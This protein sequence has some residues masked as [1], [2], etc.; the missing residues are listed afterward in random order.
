MSKFCWA[1]FRSVLFFHVFWCFFTCLFLLGSGHYH[2]LVFLLLE[3]FHF[4]GHF[5]IRNDDELISFRLLFHWWNKAK[6]IHLGEKACPKKAHKTGVCFSLI[7]SKTWTLYLN[8]LLYGKAFMCT[9]L[10]KLFFHW[11][12]LNLIRIKYLHENKALMIY[13]FILRP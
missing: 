2:S 7:H 9:V 12:V 1:V 3:T 4:S 6:T 10:N 11:M 5:F 8:S 13:C